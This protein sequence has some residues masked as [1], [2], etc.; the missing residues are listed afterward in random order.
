MRVFL[1]F[2]LLVVVAAVTPG[3][4]QRFTDPGELRLHV[5]PGQRQVVVIGSLPAPD[6]TAVHY[7]LAPAEA[8]AE[9][10]PAA[11]VSVIRGTLTVRQGEV[12]LQQFL[13]TGG[14]WR[15]RMHASSAGRSWEAR[16]AMEVTRLPLG[17]NP[18]H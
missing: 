5:Q 10:E 8:S 7:E 12:T 17:W 3:V 2:L 14:T 13:P 4:W 6:G 11:A 16:H 15:V 9:A 1:S 18:A